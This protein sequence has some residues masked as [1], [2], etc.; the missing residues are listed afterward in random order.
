[1]IGG[2]VIYLVGVILFKRSIH[3]RLQLFHLAGIGLLITLA[4][5]NIAVAAAALQ[6]RNDCSLDRRWIGAL[7]ASQSN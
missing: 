3:G 6:C 2:P 4:S 5:R 1:M 7:V